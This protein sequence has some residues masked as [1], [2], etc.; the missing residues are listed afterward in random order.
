MGIFGA[1][2]RWE[3]LPDFVDEFVQATNEPL[4]SL[5]VF[6]RSCFIKPRDK[7]MCAE[8]WVVG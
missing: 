1:S 6:A 8:P 3:L 7:Q 2:Q 4:S 5:E